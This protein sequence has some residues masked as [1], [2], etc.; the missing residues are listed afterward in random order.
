VRVSRILN[1]VR[2][3][4]RR[5]WAAALLPLGLGFL[6]AAAVLASTSAPSSESRASLSA[7]SARVL[8]RPIDVS[9]VTSHPGHQNS[10]RRVQKSRP[11]NWQMPDPVR[12]EIPAI[13]VSAPLVA[14][15]LH[16]DH[17]IEVPKRWGDAGWF[18][19][20]PEPG[21]RGAAVIAGHFDST[22]GPAVFYHLRALVKGDKITVL[23]RGGSTVHFIVVSTRAVSKKSFPAS[24]VYHKT[25]RPTLRLITCDGAFDRSTGHYVG[26]YIVFANMIEPGD[27]SLPRALSGTGAVPLLPDLVPQVPSGL[28]ITPTSQRMLIGFRSAT[29]NVGMGPLLIE[30]HRTGTADPRMTADQVVRLSGGSEQIVRGA[31]ELH[32]VVASDHQQWHLEPFMRYELVRGGASKVITRDQKSGFC[33][34]DRY[35][36][37]SRIPAAPHRAV[38]RTNCGRGNTKLTSISEGI[39]VGYGDD[40]VANLEGQYLD[41]KGVPA[42]LYYLVHRVNM[43][44]NL[45][46]ADYSNNVSWLQI[47]LT[48]HHHRAHVKVVNQCNPARPRSDCGAAVR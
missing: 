38:F 22:S 10:V 40:Y 23:L 36:V 8:P 43:S 6:G 3:G 16:R 13:G 35:A 18:R 2:H 45:V 34:G 12:I 20:G 39:S 37:R 1:R 44:R 21:E 32:Y 19:P 30:G 29:S 25:Q 7:A 46:E 17:T 24:L 41:L 48:W 47:R 31:G 4:R 28:T 42:G 27:R 26:N 15:G 14:L 33:L 9:T 5:H 11:I